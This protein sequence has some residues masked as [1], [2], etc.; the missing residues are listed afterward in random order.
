MANKACIVGGSG[1]GWQADD[2]SIQTWTLAAPGGANQA[3]ISD[4]TNWLSAFVS[5]TAGV[6]GVLPAAN[7]GVAVPG[8]G[9]NAS[10]VNFGSGSQVD[11]CSS[12]SAA[13][14][15]SLKM[16]VSAFVP[17][18][19]TVATSASTITWEIQL[20]GVTQDTIVANQNYDS[21]PLP[22][23]NTFAFS[24]TYTVTNANHVFKVRAGT[25]RA[26]NVAAGAAHITAIGL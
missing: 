23:L 3:L 21:T 10:V 8:V 16:F 25:N 17:Y 14:G 6:S 24:A 1:T 11:V 4:G 20:D 15:A 26:C 18:Q 5:L 12:S 13:P 2:A 7:G 22:V 19:Y 9:T